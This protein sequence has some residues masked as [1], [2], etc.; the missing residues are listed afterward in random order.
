MTPGK[1][2]KRG[3]IKITIGPFRNLADYDACMDIQRE[4]WHIEDIDVVPLMVLLA[5]ERQGGI[6]L[7]AYNSLGEMIGFCWSI[8]GTDHGEVLQHS[9]MLAVRAAYRNFDVGYRLKLAQRKETLRRKLNTITWTFDPMHPLNAYFNL[10]K[11]GVWSAAYHENFY[12]ESSN[13]LHR[14]L[15]TDRFM[16]RWDLKSPSVEERLDQGPPRRDLRKELKKFP[17][18]NHLEELAPGMTT[19]S[20]LK[21]NLDAVE[22]L[23]EVPYNL[24]DI[25]ARNLGVAL[26]WQGKMRQV[27]RHYFKKGYA[28][29][30]FWVAEEEGHLR[31]FYFL[32]TRGK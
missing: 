19:S 2:K 15:P 13:S 23:F 28:A 26:E 32:E 30:D 4:V 5:A 16:A 24:P 12:G 31:A 14:G 8:L 18:V 27:F 29:T 7:G 1:R 10:G 11:L 22:L 25:K 21:L 20:P 3:E 6:S 17:L 9:H